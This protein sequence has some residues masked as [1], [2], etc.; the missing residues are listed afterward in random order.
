MKYASAILICLAGVWLGGCG[1]LT[2]PWADASDEKPVP[3]TPPVEQ[4]P[5]SEPEMRDSEAAESA[6]EPLPPAESRQEPDETIVTI[7]PE[8]AEPTP[9]EPSPQGPGPTVEEDDEAG[10]DVRDAPGEETSPSE[11]SPP[12]PRRRIVGEPE[13]VAASMIQVN[14]QFIT[15][16]DVLRSVRS[17]LEQAS[18]APPQV[19]RNRAAQ[20]I[21]AETRRQVGQTLLAAEAE[22]RLTDRQKQAVEA[23]LDRIRKEMIASAG[24]SRMRLEARFSEQGVT[25]REVLDEQRRYLTV[26]FYLQSKFMPAISVTRRELWDYY[27]ENS[28]EFSTDKQVQMQLIAAPVEAY[29]P[30]MP[31]E[32]TSL[33]ISAARRKARESIEDS[34]AELNKGTDFAQVARDYSKGIKAADGGVWPLM[35]AGSFRLEKVEQ[36]AFG[37]SEGEVSD[38]IETDF[39]FYI[40]KARRVEAGETVSFEQAQERIEQTLRQQRY[41]QATQQYIEGLMGQATVVETERFITM[42]VDQAVRRFGSD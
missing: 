5:L 32:P 27:N 37:L 29:L 8:A 20:I 26:Q 38:I 2:A 30:D 7:E 6:T 9:S 24:G 39:G 28:D 18:A 22:R 17:E 4:E 41:D 10:E 3:V 40:V 23:E 34:M 19:F 35:P 21:A 25:L 13:V 16:D 11:A 12:G 33:E 42:A 36:A 31:G 1:W 15:I 14:G